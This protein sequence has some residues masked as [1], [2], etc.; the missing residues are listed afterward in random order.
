MICDGE[1]NFLDENNLQKVGGNEKGCRN[2]ILSM[3][4]RV[5]T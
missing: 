2:T 4:G 5:K 1:L 3:L